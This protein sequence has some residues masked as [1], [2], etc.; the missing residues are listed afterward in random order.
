MINFYKLLRIYGDLL[1]ILSWTSVD[2]F[3]SWRLRL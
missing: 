3:Q 1:K 2:Q